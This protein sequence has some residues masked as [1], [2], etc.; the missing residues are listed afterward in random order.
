MSHALMFQ[1]VTKRYEGFTLERMNLCVPEGCI[2]GLI[3]E[4]GAGKTTAIKLA[5]GLI[6]PD[7][8]GVE[9]LGSRDPANDAALKEHLGVVLDECFFP[10]ALTP[11]GINAVLRRSYRTWSVERFHDYARRFDLP[12]KKPVKTFS[13]GMKTKLCLA[14]ALSHD[15]RLLLLDEPTSG[16][17]VVV[18]NDVLDVM[19][20]FLQDERHTV[21][22][23][24][25]ITSDLEKVCDYIT[26][27]HK[28]R[29]LLS[30]PKDELLMDYVV[31][32][33]PAE[34]IDAL[35]P[36]AVVG[37]RRSPFGAEA[38]ARRDALPEGMARDRATLED[39]MLYCIKGDERR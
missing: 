4:N 26:F 14:V 8:G 17:D 39:I 12:M 15:S 38:L 31:A 24:S 33:A 1:G 37:M 6:A 16:L 22:F 34:E 27:L 36:Q 25:H 13:R 30:R 10:P 28:G 3:G 11:D 20:E 29:V 9:V 5:L 35:P 19:Q 23:S 2:M 7:E 18:R 32:K 21:L